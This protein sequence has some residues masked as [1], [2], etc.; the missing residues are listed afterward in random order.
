M[1]LDSHGEERDYQLLRE[2]LMHKPLE[3]L[4]ILRGEQYS[5]R[6]ALVEDIIANDDGSLEEIMEQEGSFLYLLMRGGRANDTFSKNE[7]GL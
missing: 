4:Y 1:K 2:F 3:E 5:S 7:G 6:E